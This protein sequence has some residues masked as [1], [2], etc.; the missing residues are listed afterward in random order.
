MNIWTIEKWKDKYNVS[1]SSIR[2]G[3]RL[4]FDK[5]VDDEV[6]RSCKEFCAWIRKKYFFPIRVPVYVKSSPKIKSID[7]ELVFGTFFEPECIYKEP[8]IRI[9]AGDYF[10]LI[11]KG[12]KDNALAAILATIAHELTHYFQWINDIKLTDIG[13]ERQANAYTR[14]ILNKY[15]ETRDHP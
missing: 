15:S 6:K 13:R 12:G 7:G 3:L 14:Y 5:N 11:Q 4:R 1:N 9:A 8:Y 10:D 2:T